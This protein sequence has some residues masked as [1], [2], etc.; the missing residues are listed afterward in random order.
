MH[1]GEVYGRLGFRDPVVY[2]KGYLDFEPR[3][4]KIEVMQ[5]TDIILEVDF[6]AE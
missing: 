1:D 6:P 2:G 3:G 4:Q 5:G